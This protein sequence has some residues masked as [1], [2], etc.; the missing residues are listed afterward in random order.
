MDRTTGF[1]KSDVQLPKLKVELWKGFIFVNFD[2]K[3]EALSPRL[4]R[5]ST[6]LANFHLEEMITVEVDRRRCSR[7]VGERGLKDDQVHGG[8]KIVEAGEGL[9]DQRLE[10]CALKAQ[11]ASN[12]GDPIP[13]RLVTRGRPP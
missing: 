4:G 7:V 10:Y 3:A 12:L 5:V 1:D 6:A 9:F 2:D 8:I 11:V 13:D